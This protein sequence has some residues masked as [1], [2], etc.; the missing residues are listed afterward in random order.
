MNLALLFGSAAKENFREQSDVDIALDFS[1]N[2]EKKRLEKWLT[3]RADLEMLVH[4]EIDLLD[5]SKS[6]GLI[7]SKIIESNVRLKNKPTLYAEYN[8]KAICF[9]EDFLPTL[10][11]IQNKKIAR[12]INGQSC[13]K[14]ET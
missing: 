9:N 8:L 2:D 12:F 4:R 13:F 6:E 11:E 10:R 7:L 3:I 1:A 5:L 14:S